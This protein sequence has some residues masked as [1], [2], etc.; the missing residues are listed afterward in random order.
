MLEKYPGFFKLIVFIVNITLPYNFF[1]PAFRYP[2]K[3]DENAPPRVSA[4]GGECLLEISDQVGNILKTNRDANEVRSDAHPQ[5]DIVR[6]G[7]VRHGTGML[8]E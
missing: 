5:L 6:H 1:H 4:A 8:D 2:G 3:P 7:G